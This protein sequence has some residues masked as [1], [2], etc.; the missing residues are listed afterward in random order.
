MENLTKYT[1]FDT[2]IDKVN[3][4]T[5]TVIVSK[6]GIS[7][8]TNM[9]WNNKTILANNVYNKDET[10]SV[11]YSIIDFEGNVQEN[12]LENNGILSELFK[13]PDN[14]LYVSITVY[15]PDRELDISVPLINRNSIMESK[16]N[17]P[18]AGKYIGNV[19][20]SAIFYDVDI[21]SDKKQD[22]MLNIKYKNGAIYK[23]HTVKIDFPKDNKMYINR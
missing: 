1:G 15:H 3:D 14:E 12:Y 8:K 6:N 19:N 9:E 23:K 17:R 21:F 20:Q 16:P 5:I 11:V 10:Y 22:K 18:F 13:S 7:Q 2:R 4:G